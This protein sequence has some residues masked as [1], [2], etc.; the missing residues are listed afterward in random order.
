MMV[1]FVHKP[2]DW[3][4]DHNPFGDKAKREFKKVL[5]RAAV[6]TSI[7]LSYSKQSKQLTGT[8]DL[9]YQELETLSPKVCD[10]VQLTQLVLAGNVLT[11]VRLLTH[12]MK[13][14][15]IYQRVVFV[16]DSK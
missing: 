6:R 10:V 11:S 7:V 16:V 4:L 2:K 8:L 5:K 15:A 12:A 3:I 9:S 13:A 1:S 14:I